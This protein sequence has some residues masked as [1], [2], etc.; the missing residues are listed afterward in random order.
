MSFTVMGDTVN[1]ASRLEGA[2]K[3]YASRCL[4]SAATAK[5]CGADFELREIDRLV[6]AGQS[7]PQTVYEVVGRK[8][9]LTPEQELL[10]TRYAEGLAAY[11][12]RRWD[13]ASTAFA[14]ALAAVPED[15]PTAVLMARS[16]GYSSN[17][18]AHDW[19]GAWHLEQK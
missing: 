12:D 16:R 18:P 6:A 5:M 15:G 13:K 2:N 3:V 17:P 7:Q 11:R 4:I 1:L 19:D 8:G 14:A 10:Q 9:E